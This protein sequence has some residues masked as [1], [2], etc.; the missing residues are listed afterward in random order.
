MDRSRSSRKSATKVNYSEISENDENGYDEIPRSRSK[1]VKSPVVFSDNT[2]QSTNTANTSSIASKVGRRREQATVKTKRKS[3]RNG[4]KE[5]A[6]SRLRDSSSPGTNSRLAEGNAESPNNTNNNKRRRRTKS[7]N[8]SNVRRKTIRTGKGTSPALSASATPTAAAV[9]RESL[10]PSKS[11]TKRNSV[12]NS[13]RFSNMLDFS[14]ATVGY[15]GSLRLADGSIYSPNDHIYLVAEPPS[16]PY[17]I[18]RIMEFVHLSEKYDMARHSSRVSSN[19]NLVLETYQVRVNWFYRPKD[20]PTR[21]NDSRLLFATMH[22]DICPLLSIRGKCVITH[23]AHIKDLTEY[24]KV[25]DHFWFDKLYDR[26]ICR[27]YEMIPTERILNVPEEFGKVLREKVKFGVVEIGRGKDLSSIA[28]NCVRCNQWCPPDESVCCAVCGTFYHMSCVKPPLLRKPTRGFAWACALCN[29]D[30]E[31][32]VKESKG[33]LLPETGEE[34]SSISANDSSEDLSLEQKSST[35]EEIEDDDFKPRPPP[36]FKI[37]DSKLTAEQKKEISLWPYRYLGIHCTLEDVLDNNDRIFPRAASRIGNKHQAV[38]P[39][40]GGRPVQFI[41][42]SPVKT[43]KKRHSKQQAK[44]GNLQAILSN[45]VKSESEDTSPPAV[46][47]SSQLSN[48]NLSLDDPWVQ[49]KPPGYIKRGGDDTVELMWK[50]PP[51]IPEK[52]IDDFLIQAEPYAEKLGIKGY[53]SNFMDSALYS[54]MKC[55][56]QTNSALVE[57]SKFTRDT[58]KE[59]TLT[60]DEIRR[61]EDGVRKFGSELHPVFKAVGTVS[62]RD[63]VRFYYLWKKTPNGHAIW[64]NFEGRRR[65]RDPSKLEPTVKDNTN[66]ILSSSNAV[67]ADYVADSHDDSAYDMNKCVKFKQQFSCKFCK[68]T[69]SAA[70]RRAPGSS[71]VKSNPALALCIRC[72]QLWRRYAVVWEDPNKL[73]KKVNQR[74]SRGSRRK[75][76]EELLQELVD[77]NRFELDPSLSERDSENESDSRASNDMVS[78]DRR[79]RPQNAEN[80]TSTPSFQRKSDPLLPRRCSVCEKTEPA[81]KVLRCSSCQMCVHAACYGVPELKSKKW[82]CEPCQNDKNPRNSVH[83]ECALCPARIGESKGTETLPKTPRD[84]LKFTSGNNWV[85]VNCAVWIP[86]IKFT[87][88]YAMQAAEGIGLIPRSHFL[89]ECEICH[90]QHGVCTTCAACHATFHVGC[91]MKANYKLGFDMQPVKS[92]RRDS[93]AITKLGSETGVMTPMVWCPRHDLK[94]FTIHE[95]NEPV[96]GTDD[97]D[98]I[99]RASDKDKRI[100]LNLYCELYKQADLSLTGTARR[101]QQIIAASKFAVNGHIPH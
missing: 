65:K 71:A 72:A 2:Q 16:E 101:A 23:K 51:N 6:V 7:P 29:R 56:F 64:D 60:V 18:G 85:H 58:L 49:E 22:S 77:G 88:A 55:D 31:R 37:S 81:E 84:A 86:E 53:S 80:Q 57:V 35:E 93:F 38:V 5:Q 19:S 4:N 74:G 62:S 94:K 10:T 68:A 87:D 99:T 45:E 67:L 54:L 21:S 14:N 70:W 39:E 33:N 91:A 82:L 11:M 27:F 78:K 1:Q 20:I 25:P 28:T 95:I 48:R 75:V 36:E 61:F 8:N 79:K 12:S 13:N 46:S 50:W 73:L 26:Y 9:K 30:N 15:D 89:R 76:E 92:S 47:L 52:V 83:Y 40:W 63:I 100:A 44:R 42:S 43:K 24:R 34:D 96:T 98:N 3:I 66:V 41:E 97:Q 90:I 32:K 17:Y 69:K 59:P